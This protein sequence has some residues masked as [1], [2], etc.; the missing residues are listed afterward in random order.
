MVRGIMEWIF[1]PTRL[2]ELF[3]R[4]FDGVKKQQEGEQTKL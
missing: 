1:E 3:E 2:D 4:Q